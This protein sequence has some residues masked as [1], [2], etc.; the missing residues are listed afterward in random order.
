MASWIRYATSQWRKSPRHIVA[1]YSIFRRE[2]LPRIEKGE[3][4]LV[5]AHGNSLRAM[6]KYLENISDADILELEILL[7]FPLSTDLMFLGK[8][9]HSGENSIHTSRRK[10]T[11]EVGSIFLK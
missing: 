4:V 6:T 9:N 2:I 10:F 7:A 3:T 5:S 11:V 8:N 1:E